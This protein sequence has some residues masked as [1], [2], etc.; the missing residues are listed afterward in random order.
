[1]GSVAM[2][3]SGLIGFFFQAEDGIRD[4]LV[5]GVQTCALPIYLRGRRSLFAL[6]CGTAVVFATPSAPG[7][8]LFGSE[9]LSGNAWFRTIAE[10]Q[11]IWTTGFA[12]R[13]AYLSTGVIFVWLLLA[14]AWRRRDALLG[15]VAGFAIVELLLTLRNV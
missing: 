13:L 3:G 5:T 10:G 9:Y 14:V 1:M 8:I 6:L 11:A 7:A 4:K 2:D 15:I 12:T